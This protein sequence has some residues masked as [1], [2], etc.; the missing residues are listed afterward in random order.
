MRNLG[1]GLVAAGIFAGGLAAV[2]HFL[3]GVEFAH[4]ATYLG[5]L[6][7]VLLALGSWMTLGAKSAKGK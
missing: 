3:Y 6:G 1:P 7:L 2:Q 5:V 4:L